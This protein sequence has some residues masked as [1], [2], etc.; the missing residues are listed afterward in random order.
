MM[1]PRHR[2]SGK[3]VISSTSQTVNLLEIL[4][5]WVPAQRRVLYKDQQLLT[6]RSN[7][8]T[9]TSIKLSLY[10]A[11]AIIILAG[12]AL[13]NP[14]PNVDAHANIVRESPP[15]D[16]LL[17]A[18]PRSI[19]LW[20]TERVASGAGSP[21]IRVLNEDG[22][23]QDITVTNV[24]VDP[25]DPRHVVADVEGIGA[26]T[27]T[28]VW[29]LR[30]D[31]DGHTL[32]GSYA[33]RVAGT[34]RA[35]GAA[36]V[37]GESPRTWAVVTRWLTFL[38]AAIAAAGFL[39][40]RFL[41]TRGDPDAIHRRRS[42]SI[43]IGSAV[44][45]I[46]TVAEPLLQTRFPA[47]GAA[48]P[49][50]GDAIA[51][52]PLAW[53][54]RPGSLV[55]AL[56]LGL[57]LLIV[58]R[59]A[60]GNDD[61]LLFVGA[62]IALIS[63]LGLALTSH[64]SAR[65]TWRIAAV[66]SII[67]HQ[68]SVGLW[69]G[70]LVQL[71][72]SWSQG[73]AYNDTENAEEPMPDP[74]RQF[75]RYALVLALIGIG[76]GVLNAG[77][78]LPTLRSLWNSDYGDILIIKVAVLVP[79]LALASFHRLTLHQT[80]RR[81]GRSLRRTVRIEAALILVVVL[82]GSVLALLA[83]PTI[84][85]GTVD[86]LDLAAPT[87]TGTLATDLVIRLQ[88]APAK[89]GQNRMTVLVADIN[90]QPIPNDQ[91]A[92]VRLGLTSLDHDAEQPEVE[93]IPSPDGGFTSQGVQLSLAD[94][95]RVDVL[96]RRLGMEDVSVPFFLRL[97]DPNLN[98][99]DVDTSSGSAE[100]RSMF[101]QGL[102]GMTSMTSVQW[103]QR[104]ADGGGIVLLSNLGVSAPNGDEPATFTN[105]SYEYIPADRQ[106]T[107]SATPIPTTSGSRIP[108]FE[109]VVIGTN[110]W[111]RQDGGQW[112]K[113]EASSP[114]LPSQWGSNYD[115]ATNFQMGRQEE[116]D[117]VM[118]QVISFVVPGTT[119]ATAYYTWWVDPATGQVLQETMVSRSH[120]M[121]YDY[122]N[123]NQPLPI[124]PPAS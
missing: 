53:W 26:G 111:Q 37:E 21:A 118:T 46:A 78:V 38:G 16:G 107:L 109:Q 94:W 98:G 44:A 90:G 91:I 101:E 99:F 30:S 82:G 65:E 80:A 31:D 40:G 47:E 77:L 114:F 61:A 122:H 68:W 103:S 6:S 8:A 24:R 12:T 32:N 64:A 66:P 58:G 115:G 7:I 23:A 27:Y 59:R 2:L 5:K 18:P 69:V 100:A 54:L 113:G 4:W 120:Y 81:V 93:T 39:A 14:A 124:A 48:K 1:C 57:V 106:Q 50:L 3:R 29:S 121:V 35:P 110:R 70:G 117:G 11:F 22:S 119:V 112:L 76:T 25:N 52:L 123:I 116:V 97:P 108:S 89:P 19:E 49:T 63:L 28:V 55:V 60:R 104:L 73:N 56:A 75:S 33:F 71:A 95:W 88:I 43:I 45:L 67:L 62:A 41:T 72:L 87:G 105:T 17:G 9:R 20:T 42:S 15:E 34:A 10:L 86:L 102:Q 96:I 13:F 84:A 85:R 51:S 92:L 74:V 36:A 79:V 83:P